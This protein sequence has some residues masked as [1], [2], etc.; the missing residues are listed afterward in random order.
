MRDTMRTLLQ[1]DQCAGECNRCEP[2][3]KAASV[4]FIQ[5]Q[6]ASICR[7]VKGLA[8]AVPLPAPPLTLTVVQKQVGMGRELTGKKSRS[9]V[10]S[11][12]ALSSSVHTNAFVNNV[13]CARDGL[14]NKLTTVTCTH[15]PAAYTSN[16]HNAVASSSRAGRMA[17]VCTVDKRSGTAPTVSVKGVSAL[18]NSSVQPIHGGITKVTWK[19]KTPLRIARGEF[20]GILEEKNSQH[21][22]GHL[23]WLMPTHLSLTARPAGWQMQNCSLSGH[24][25]KHTSSSMHC[26]GGVSVQNSYFLSYSYNVAV[27]TGNDNAADDGT[28]MLHF[29]AHN[30]AVRTAEAVARLQ[31]LR[32]AAGSKLK[33]SSFSLPILGQLPPSKMGRRWRAICG[34][35]KT[36]WTGGE[37]HKRHHHQQRIERGLGERLDTLVCHYGPGCFTGTWRQRS[38]LA[39]CGGNRLAPAAV[40]AYMA[41]LAS[42]LVQRGRSAT[43]TRT[44]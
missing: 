24:R 38:T 26:R 42:D 17:F 33:S 41:A 27:T 10:A 19:L 44:L 6:L 32:A 23:G 43:R 40:A 22:V 12:T 4:S 36:K 15:T 28:G 11:W 30:N 25:S 5:A 39:A 20:V 37:K 3:A 31:R 21:F 7:G 2:A 9:A 18:L 8:V 1:L 34:D 16:A 35:S 14:V 13:P 29:R